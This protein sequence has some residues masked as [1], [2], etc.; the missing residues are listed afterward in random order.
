MKSILILSWLLILPLIFLTTAFVRPTFADICEDKWMQTL[1]VTSLPIDI[2][3]G[4]TKLIRI[5]MNLFVYGSNPYVNYSLELK[6]AFQGGHVE[7]F[8]F[9]TDADGVGTVNIYIPLNSQNGGVSLW[10]S[11][12]SSAASC[13]GFPIFNVGGGPTP[14]SGQN[15]C[16]T[17]CETALGNI[18]TDISGFAERILQIGIGLAGGIS[19]ILMVIGSIRVL[20]S[21]GEQQRLAGG[22]DMIVAAIAGLLFLIFSVLILKFI[23]VEIIKIPGFG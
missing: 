2:N 3:V 23:G 4:E 10:V 1:G 9:R 7:T 22:R 13:R 14:A 15:P 11:D 20:T 21:S 5:D 8:P 18:P 12:G 17:E 16:G 6:V 19:L